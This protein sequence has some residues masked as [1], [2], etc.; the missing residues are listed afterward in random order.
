MT[1]RDDGTAG[2]MATLLTMIGK[3]DLGSRM[4][5]SR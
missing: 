4:G 1:G 3:L 2:P 5:D